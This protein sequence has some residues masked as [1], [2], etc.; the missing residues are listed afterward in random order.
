[1]SNVPHD[2]HNDGDDN[3]GIDN[4]ILLELLS[5]MKKLNSTMKPFDKDEKL[6]HTS[7][8]SI[9]IT[10]EDDD[11]GRGSVVFEKN[12]FNQ[13]IYTKVIKLEVMLNEMM[14]KWFLIN[15]VL[16]DVKKLLL[17]YQKIDVMEADI[18][19]IKKDVSSLNEKTKNNKTFSQFIKEKSEM[20]D[21]VIKIFKFI[22]YV[23]FGAYLLFNVMPGL[24]TLL[25]TIN[26]VN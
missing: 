12:Q 25:K 5:E 6:S 15:P 2:Q 21:S 10:P 3:K 17:S 24:G 22:L 4:G 19:S 9:I 23:L 11:Q 13:M 20:S 8:D 14:D 18:A 16:S 26:G 7:N 1:M